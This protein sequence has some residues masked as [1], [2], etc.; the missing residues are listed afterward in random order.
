MRLEVLEVICNDYLA[1]IRAAAFVGFSRYMAPVQFLA[2][3][4]EPRLAYQ[5][6]WHLCNN[7]P[8]SLNRCQQAID[9]NK[10]FSGSDSGINAEYRRPDAEASEVQNQSDELVKF[11]G[12]M[13]AADFQKFD[14]KIAVLQQ[15]LAGLR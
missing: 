8:R 7:R 9:S 5:G 6:A 14:A 4:Q 12:Q 11:C 2:P 1:A 3:V 15:H 13:V 10:A